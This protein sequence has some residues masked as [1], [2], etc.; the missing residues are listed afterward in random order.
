M[1]QCQAAQSLLQTR[2]ESPWVKVNLLS[3]GTVLQALFIQ[4][5][6]LQYMSLFTWLVAVE[7]RTFVP[8]FICSYK[9]SCS[10]SV[11][12]EGVQFKCTALLLLF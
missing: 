11:S 12:N 8:L 3:G 4:E 9:Y 2:H 6:H 10:K 5:A 7:I 1:H